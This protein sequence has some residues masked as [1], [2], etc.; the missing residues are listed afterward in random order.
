[1]MTLQLWN[2][3][4]VRMKSPEEK[5]TISYSKIYFYKKS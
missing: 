3:L 2:A 4:K 5:K 1:M